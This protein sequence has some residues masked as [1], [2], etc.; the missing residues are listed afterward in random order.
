MINDEAS[1]Q[2]MLDAIFAA[3]REINCGLLDI[4]PRV[5]EAEFSG[6]KQAAGKVLA[7]MLFEF[8]NLIL[9]VHPVLT[10]EG[11]KHNSQS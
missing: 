2:R 11:L 9:K 1:A 8:I 5:T 10:P 4:Q 7:G 6:I 3:S